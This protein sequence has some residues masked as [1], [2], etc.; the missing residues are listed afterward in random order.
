VLAT[1]S[2]GREATLNERS[3]PWGRIPAGFIENQGQID[4]Q[5]K[6]YARANGQT[7]WM[8]RGGIVLD[9][10]RAR[11]P[12]GPSHGTARAR[13]PSAERDRFVLLQEYVGSNPTGTIAPEQPQAGVYN[14]LLGSDPT[15]W[16]SG[17]RAYGQIVYHDVWDGIDLRVHHRG[18]DLEQ[19]FVVKPGGDSSR[20]RVAYRGV[21]GL[22]IAEDGSLLIRTA[23]GELR[24]SAPTIYQEVQGKR[25]AVAGR[26]KL[27]SATSYAFEVGAYQRRYALVIDPTLSYAT[28]L[29]GGGNEDTLGQ[30][31][32]IDGAG[33]VYV[34]GSTTSFNFPAN[35]LQTVY[36]GGTGLLNGGPG[37]DVFV[38]K[39]NAAGNALVYATFLG[40][41]GD[42]AASGL[43]VDSAGSVYITGSTTSTNFPTTA[44]AFQTTRKTTS[45]QGFVAKLNPTG[46]ALVYSTYLGGSSGE[47]GG[48]I[49][50]D[51][52]GHAYITGITGSSDF[53]TLNSLQPFRGTGDAFITK[54]APDGSGLVYSTL[55][56]GS[57]NEW[58]KAITVDAAGNAYVAGYTNSTDFPTANAAQGSSA[59]GN[60][61][62]ASAEAFVTKLN[63]GGTAFVYSTYLGGSGDDQAAAIAVDAAGNAYVTGTT[64]STNFPTVSAYQPA[65]MPGS[66]SNIFVT[67]LTAAGAI[68]YSTFLG[69]SGGGSG[70]GIAVDALGSA[71]VTGIN[72]S[73]DFPIVDAFQ[74]VQGPGFIGFVTAFTPSGT[75]L[76][77]SSFLGGAGRGIAVDA[78]GNAYVAGMTTSGTSIPS[79]FLTFAGGQDAFVVKVASPA[80]DVS[81]TKFGNPNPVLSLA[82]LTYTITVHNA[83]PD[84]AFGVSLTDTVPVGTTFQSMTPSAGCTTPAVDGTGTV[85][86]SL[87]AMAPGASVELTLV[88]KVT[89]VT[90]SVTNTASV[91]TQ[92]QDPTPGNNS[93]TA[94]TS[95]TAAGAISGTVCANAGPPCVAAV[96]PPLS[97]ALISVRNSDSGS[98]VAT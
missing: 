26:F 33:A 71:Y 5:V 2:P 91:T 20:I 75:A 30:N 72:T 94:V 17:L 45:S 48:G 95:V 59:G 46:T 56:G 54:L 92:S 12:S 70:S 38:A 82:N 65:P 80:A 19:E 34:A 51:A 52:T 1:P 23:F 39:L 37:G 58:G 73:S 21:E 78:N 86:C 61:A 18:R 96:N 62:L 77:Y 13:E 9:L 8:I 24:E 36:G 87:G 14:Y 32:A 25:V 74:P 57:S 66:T 63:P 53:P 10:T 68:A 6:F 42:E 7:I 88:V 4:E 98:T 79:S 85:T 35:G 43:A 11:P 29:G 55:L 49:A 69:G 64:V 22:R 89:A 44:G 28:Y 16:R 47:Q 67:K 84:A 41:S 40:D 90:G 50:V 27:L 93:A 83:G 76:V 60:G 3:G 31:I 81:V 15:K 97:G